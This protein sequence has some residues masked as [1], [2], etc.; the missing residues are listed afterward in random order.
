MNA[1]PFT[2][3]TGGFG[4]L[5][6]VGLAVGIYFAFFSKAG[7]AYTLQETLAD[8]IHDFGASTRVVS[9]GSGKRRRP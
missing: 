5:A 3:R 9:P 4:L 8:M 7:S 2:L 1:A 6:I